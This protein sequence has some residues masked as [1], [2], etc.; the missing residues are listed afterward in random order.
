MAI[1]SRKFHLAWLVIVILSIG[2]FLL[3]CQAGLS[4]SR[5]ILLTEIA[6]LALICLVTLLLFYQH[7][8]LHH[9]LASRQHIEMD[10]LTGL[11]T[12]QSFIP[13]ITAAVDKARGS[14]SVLS[15]LLLDI[16]SLKQINDR[17]GAQ[18]G[19][20]ILCR[21]AVMIQ[22]SIRGWDTASR[23]GGD[24]FCVLLPST[25]GIDAVAVAERL[26]AQAS[27]ISLDD[28]SGANLSVSIGVSC[29]S[30][31]IATAEA[32]LTQANRCL[33]EGKRLKGNQVIVDW[34]H[35]LETVAEA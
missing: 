24:E 6:S 8:W 5:L 15:L 25:S 16:D 32:L 19:D 7:R 22:G 12:R 21:V 28:E 26:R 31:E 30:S 4:N 10:Y 35:A 11:F 27:T 1:L 29:L 13:Q 34:E 20:D 14:N 18:L 33:A 9:Q 2:N 17:Y 23:F 3:A